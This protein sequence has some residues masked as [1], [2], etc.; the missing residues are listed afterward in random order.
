MSTPASNRE[1]EARDEALARLYVIP[2][3]HA[4]RAAMLMLA[5]KGIAYELRELP[6]GTHPMVVRLLGFPGNRSPI[7]TVDGHTH[8]ALAALDRLGTVPALAWDGE[9]IQTNRSIARFLEYVQPQPPL[10]PAGEDARAAVEEAEAWGDEVLQMAARRIVMAAAARGADALH[11]GGGSGRLGALLVGNERVRIFASRLFGG[12]IFRAS[13][14]TEQALLAEL[15]AM[16]DRVDAWIER[17]V[18]AGAELTAADYMIAPSI[19]L[20]SYRRDLC[21]EIARRP[22]GALIDRLLPLP[23]RRAPES[24]ALTPPRASAR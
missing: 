11:D 15:P 20:L 12:V 17:G 19:A 24:A 3:S 1:R 9:R 14:A 13:A 18:L 16:L 7:R 22:A 21:A 5:H 2:G 23:A 8:A 10:L 6:S 4:C